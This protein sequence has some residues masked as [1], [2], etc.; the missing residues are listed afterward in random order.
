MALSCS[1]LKCQEQ[2][3][4]TLKTSKA[5]Q[6]LVRDLRKLWLCLLSKCLHDEHIHTPWNLD[7]YA[8]WSSKMFICFYDAIGVSTYAIELQNLHCLCCPMY[9]QTK[10]DFSEMWIISNICRAKQTLISSQRVHGWGS[11]LTSSGFIL[12]KYSASFFSACNGLVFWELKQHVHHPIGTI[13][14][15][16]LSAEGCL[17]PIRWCPRN[18]WTP[19]SWF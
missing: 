14:I 16:P 5:G 12:G 13:T 2:S 19:W 17:A 7:F 3:I 4:S 11:T 8:S 6:S 1:S 15:Y 18:N 9:W 10:W